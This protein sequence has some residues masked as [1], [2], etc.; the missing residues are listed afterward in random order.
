LNDT[1]GTN[2]ADLVGDPD[3]VDRSVTRWFNSAAYAQPALG[4]LGNLGRNTER[5]PGVNNLDLA[6]FKNFRVAGDF[7]LQFRLESFNAFNHTQFATVSAN[8]AAPN[9]GVVTSARAAR[10]NQLGVKLLF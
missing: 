9:F 3:A 5:G 7:R 1:A 6:L 10:I 8:L 4:A 2:R